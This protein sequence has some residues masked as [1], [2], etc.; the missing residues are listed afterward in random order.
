VDAAEIGRLRTQGRAVREIA[1]ELEYSRSL[2]HKTLA[3]RAPQSVAT[4]AD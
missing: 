2:V 4:G 3:N 1:D